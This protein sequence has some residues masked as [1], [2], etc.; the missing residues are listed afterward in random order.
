M[1]LIPVATAALCL[2][3]GCR[4]HTLE[5]G[6]YAFTT[7]E[8]L[9]D[10]CG[11]A[12]TFTVLDRGA[13]LTTG[14]LVKFAF[15]SGKPDLQGTYEFQREA[16]VMDG[17]IANYRLPLR[18]KDCLLDTVS[19]HMET[20]TVDSRNFTGTSSVTFQSLVFPECNCKYWYSFTAA[21]VN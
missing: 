8:V 16:L 18:G 13:L 21:K 19:L 11:A 20:E 6:E 15:T 7:S 17:V 12:G 4:T 10:D 9:R 2:L 3:A 5:D 1:R 14:N